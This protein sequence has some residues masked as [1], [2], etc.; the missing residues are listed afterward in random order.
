MKYRI[1]VEMDE[2]R[3]TEYAIWISED[4]DIWDEIKRL[5]CHGRFNRVHIITDSACGSYA[6]GHWDI[7]QLI[8]NKEQDTQP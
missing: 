7:Q 8:K 6:V 2:K 4:G 1:T 5:K 3:N